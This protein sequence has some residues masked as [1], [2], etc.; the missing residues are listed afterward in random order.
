MLMEKK[1][2]KP[3]GLADKLGYAFGD[4]G[5]DFTFMLSSMFMMKFYTDIMEVPGVIVGILMM[6]A[7]FVDAF[8]DVTMGQIVD[9]SKPT[10]D[11]KFKPWIRRMCGPLGISAFLIFQ[12]GFAG[13]PMAFKIFWMFFTYLLW[14]SIFYTSVNIPYGSMA[15]AVSAEPNDRVQL[16]TFRS[17]GAAMASLVIGT[18]TPLVAYT[19][20]DGATVLSGP[21]MTVIAGV[22]AVCGIICHLS[23]A[24]LPS[25]N[26]AC[27]S[28]SE[29]YKTECNQDAEK[30]CF[31]PLSAGNHCSCNPSAAGNA[32]NDR[33]G[34]LCL[35]GLL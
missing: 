13:M 35:P 2:V 8:T 22:F 26:R 20:V 34:T 24:L 5:N 31:Q 17:M 6:V 12:S 3:F 32:W 4:F 14:G 30:H 29:H 33:Y 1:Q 10:K 7:R 28:S 11:G 9:R 18:C 19:V 16:S 23:S 21:R 15:S 25:G 27:G